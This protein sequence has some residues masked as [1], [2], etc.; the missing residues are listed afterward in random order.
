MPLRRGR[1]VLLPRS[2]ACL[3]SEPWVVRR[4]VGSQCR[5]SPPH[6]AQGRIH[7]LSRREK[8]CGGV[9]RDPAG[10]T[11]PLRC[12]KLSDFEAVS[13]WRPGRGLR[14]SCQWGAD[15]LSGPMDNQIAIGKRKTWRTIMPEK[16]Q[17]RAA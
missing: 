4:L 17:A 14:Y 7:H 13:W 1:P 8:P 9:A 5:L 6:K 15:V 10:S 16:G 11:G 12:V 2:E 3:G